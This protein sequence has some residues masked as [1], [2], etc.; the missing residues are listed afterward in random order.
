MKLTDLGLCTKID[1]GLPGAELS[2][3]YIMSA[4]PV[5][6][7]PEDAANRGHKYPLH[8]PQKVD[9][10]EGNRGTISTSTSTSSAAKGNVPESST[11]RQNYI[12]GGEVKRDPHDRKLA[13][14]TVGT[15]GLSNYCIIR[16]I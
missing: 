4:P 11:T 3:D 14:S 1:D 10:E 2:L 15:P 9:S 12:P 13:F 16:I 7:N 5:E 6:T 8:R